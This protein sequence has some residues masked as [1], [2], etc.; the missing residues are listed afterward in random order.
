MNRR[1]FLSLS[2]VATGT[3]LLYPTESFRIHH[4]P[5]DIYQ[6][7]ERVQEHLFPEG[8]SIPS[9]K[10]FKATLFLDET[11]AHPSFDKDI[12]AFVIE[13]AESL[14]EREDYMFLTYDEVRREKALRAFEETSRGSGWLS[15]IMILTL[16]GMLSDPLYGGN[17][18][19]SGWQA[20]GTRGGDPRPTVRYV[21][22]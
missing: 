6:L 5:N 20:L 19:E 10:E 14:Q 17:S 2:A 11:L 7:I 9:A 16:E 13:G 3:T 8:G 21:E 18:G 22:L 12:K 4:L 15:R 1:V